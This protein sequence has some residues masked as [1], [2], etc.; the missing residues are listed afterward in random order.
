MVIAA[1]VC[2]ITSASAIDAPSVF[3]RVTGNW[4]WHEFGASC[5]EKY[6][7]ISFNEER[8]R[9]AL[10]SSAATVAYFGGSSSTAHYTI[11]SYDDQSITMSMDGEHRLDDEGKP[12]IWILSLQDNNTFVWDLVHWVNAA[13]NH[14][15]WIWEN[16]RIRCG[17][18]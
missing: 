12:V 1:L 5:S 11:H 13:T 9:A 14:D 3:D 15:E 7:T 6:E 10:H 18:Q 2:D 16:R 17:N 8:T 4:A